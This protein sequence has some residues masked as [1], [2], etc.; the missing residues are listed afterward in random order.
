MHTSLLIDNVALPA[1]R[2]ATFSRR[3]PVSGEIVT[4]AAAAAPED[5]KAAVASCAAAFPSW[6]RTAPAHRRDL[7]LQAA[8][9]LDDR[10]D[11]LIEAMIAET[12]ASRPWANFNV[13]LAAGMLREAAGMTTQVK[14][15]VIPSNKPGSFSMALRRPAGVV[16]SIAPWNAP[17]IL[18]VRSFCTALA[19]GNTVV[20]K[21]SE[22]S[23]AT[24]YLLARIMI[25]AGLPPGVLNFI[26][27]APADA[28]AV[29]ERMIA[30]PAVRRVNFTGSTATGRAVAAVC[31]RY[32]K[33][34]LLE[35]GGKAPMLVLEDAPIDDAARAALF[36][37]FIHQGQVCMSTER[38]VVHEKVADAFVQRLSQLAA[39]LRAADPA[40]PDPAPLG[41]LVDESAARRVQAL[42][43]DAV[44]KGATPCVAGHC[45]GA[46]M[47]ATVLD[48][49]TPGMQIY[50]EESFGPVACIV[51][52]S[53]VAEA[54][55]VA[56]DTEYGLSASIF[57][58]DVGLALDLA[59][60]LDFGCC[61]INGPTVH[62][63]A[64]MPLGGV[65][66]SGYG[67]FGGLPGVHEFT[68]VQWVSIEDPA[69]H[70][71]I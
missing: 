16:L 58:R 63:E 31:A 37:A 11:R 18:S 34:V 53:D 52:V 55:E 67:R 24:Q 5:A 50:H 62:D 60:R 59:S 57:T 54:V 19:C 65:K 29:V 56:N 26:T 71:P 9:L 33:P 70:Y 6:S 46:V 14:G 61:H 13:R 64:Q 28:A 44:A 32:L 20:L 36:G 68:E 15:E 51:R 43:D 22:I 21:A 49:V 48:H 12:G 66:A 47:S 3:N 41:A 17:V 39:G 4:T 1:A 10:S 42:I 8:A 38:I 7:L 45:D 30:D 69:Q 25:D 2:G 23:P 35:L 40:G 27:H